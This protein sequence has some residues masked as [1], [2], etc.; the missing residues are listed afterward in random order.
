MRLLQLCSLIFAFGLVASTGVAAEYTAN[1][2]PFPVGTLEQSWHDASR[3]RDVPVKIYFPK[4]ANTDA[5]TKFPVIIFSHGLGGSREGYAYLGEHWASCG[6]IVVHPQHHGSDKDVMRGFRPLKALR[7]AAANP[8]NAIDRPLDISFVIDR[9][10]ALDADPA[11]PLHGELDLAHLGVAGHS[12]GAFTTM[13]VAGAHFPVLGHDRTYLDP[14]V[15][16]AIAMSTPAT[17]DTDEAFDDV[18]IPVFHMTGTKDESPGR[19]RKSESDPVVG[20]TSAEQRL[21]PF[22]H[23]RHAP[24]Y[25]LVF[26]GGDHMVFSGRL[27]ESRPSDGEFQARVLSGS[28]AFWDAWLKGDQ[29][30][31][32]WLDE[33]GFSADLGKLGTFETSLPKTA[34]SP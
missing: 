1:P 9:L 33:G 30:A 29:E 5:P 11:F 26:E 14:R 28:A 12:F 8:V 27:T 7:E 32:H 10:T 18:K 20:N 21:W 23:T 34:A 3:N 31:R 2:G 13:A 16:A 4:S 17:Q 24:A 19:R 6:Y 22:R 15:K 25:L